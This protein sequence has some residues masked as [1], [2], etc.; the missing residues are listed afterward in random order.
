[1][2]LVS[3]IMGKIIALFTLQWVEAKQQMMYVGRV[4]QYSQIDFQDIIAYASKAT[5]INEADM[6]RSM[7]AVFDA[8][9]Y[10][11]TEGHPVE[12][13]YLGLFSFAIN[14]K[15]QWSEEEARRSA[16]DGVYRKKITFRPNVQLKALVQNCSVICEVEKG[17]RSES[18]NPQCTDLYYKKYLD[19]RSSRQ[20]MWIEGEPLQMRGA[21]LLDCS[22]VLTVYD[23]DGDESTQTLTPTQTGKDLFSVTPDECYGIKTI[24][25]MNGS[26]VVCQRSFNKAAGDPYIASVKVNGAE[27]LPGNNTIAKVSGNT[28]NVQ[29]SGFGVDSFELQVDS[30]EKAWDYASSAIATV[31]LTV[32]GSSVVIKIGNATYNVALSEASAIVNTLTANGVS[33][34]NGGSS[35]II[36]G[37]TYHFTAAGS[38][39]ASVVSSEITGP[40]TVSGFAASANQINFDFVPSGAGTLNIADLF[41]V[42]LTAATSGITSIGGV[43]N[44]G[45][46]AL[47]SASESLAIVGTVPEDATVTV[48]GNGSA[49]AAFD[50]NR[51]HLNIS[52]AN[53]VINTIT[54]QNGTT[55]IFQFT[56]SYDD[57]PM[58]S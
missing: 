26:D 27:I 53:G 29:V 6:Y 35:A 22:V 9:N 36:A 2:N 21:N 58:G 14:A 10:F 44:G 20:V 19:P 4:K 50:T 38:N 34:Q 1:M 56:V 54:I 37:Q 48:S 18:D 55:T 5:N 39:L 8:L 15:A 7:D 42:T 23:E 17:G 16:L 32:T 52:N 49:T 31:A 40:G 12:L 11:V 13:P 3:T 33:V 47:S 41:S 24:A 28:Y 43:S 45:S 46:K 25:I 51:T 30:E 57:L